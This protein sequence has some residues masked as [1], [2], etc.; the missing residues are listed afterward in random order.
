MPYS[1]LNLRNTFSTQDDLFQIE[2][3]V[4]CAT[5]A[6]IDSDAPIVLKYAL[7][8]YRKYYIRNLYPENIF[9]VILLDERGRYKL[10]ETFC[11]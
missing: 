4:K 3:I 1:D 10:K 2:F 9:V 7:Q 8:G 6:K 5:A 11:V